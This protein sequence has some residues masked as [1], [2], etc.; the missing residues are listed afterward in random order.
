MRIAFTCVVLLAGCGGDKTVILLGAG[1]G[2]DGCN[3]GFFQSANGDCIPVGRCGDD[4]DCDAS[5]V[6]AATDICTDNEA[7]RPCTEDTDCHE[8]ELCS[9]RDLCVDEGDCFGDADCRVAG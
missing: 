4:R 9:V 8:G 1:G 5:Q 7:S 6:C 2:P 3:A